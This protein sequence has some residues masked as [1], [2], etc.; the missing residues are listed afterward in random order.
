MS[1]LNSSPNSF[2]IYPPPPH[3]LFFP[4]SSIVIVRGVH[5]YKYK[6]NLLSWFI[7]A[8]LHI[9]RDDHLVL[10]NQLRRSPLEKTASLILSSHVAL[11]LE[12]GPYEVSPS[13][14]GISA[15]D[16]MVQ[17]LSRQPDYWDFMGVASPSYI[18]ATISQQMSWLS[19]SYNLSHPCSMLFSEPYV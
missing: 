4:F 16:V 12:V 1:L 3:P 9:F 17:I 6:S 13:H 19:G 14:P 7:V 2:Q 10:N 8:H 5:T 11:H 18:E 15:S